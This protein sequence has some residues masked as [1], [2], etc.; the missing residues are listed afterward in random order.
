[1]MKKAIL[2]MFI[3][4]IAIA[5]AAPLSPAAA[6]TPGIFVDDAL[7]NDA[8]KKGAVAEGQGEDSPAASEAPPSYESPFTFFTF[9]KMLAALGFVIALIYGLLKFI[10]SKSNPFTSY[11][12]M[13]NVGGVPLGSNK[14]IQLIRLGG[15]ILVV[16]V[17]DTVTLLKEIENEEEISELIR[18]ADGQNRHG[19]PFLLFEKL[20]AK[21]EKQQD[22]NRPAGVFKD[23]MKHQLE[24]TAAERDRVLKNAVQ[25]KDRDEQ[26]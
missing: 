19:Q 13:E 7:K 26:R 24:K 14:S 10:N 4:F 21:N 8:G 23:I 20:K 17:G 1:M 12:S 18:E 25:Q 22:Q 16:G 5:I 6:S 9:I 11:R 15:R 2:L 3:C